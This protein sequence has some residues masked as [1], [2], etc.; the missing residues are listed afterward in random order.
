MRVVP[1]MMQHWQPLGTLVLPNHNGEGLPTWCRQ[2]GV[3][4]L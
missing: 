2:L 1:L 4:E 3:A